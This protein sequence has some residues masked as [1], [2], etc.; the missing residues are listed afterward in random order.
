MDKI[1]LV[2]TAHYDFK[3]R[4]RLDRLLESFSP[5]SIVV[6][7]SS[8]HYY[9]GAF[10]LKDLDWL[11]AKS[12]E[13]INKDPWAPMLFAMY[14]G[15]FYQGDRS[16]INEETTLLFLKN[17]VFETR[18][19]MKFS[20]ENGKKFI[21]VDHDPNHLLGKELLKSLGENEEYSSHRFNGIRELLKMSPEQATVESQKAYS[22]DN[23][24]HKRFSTK[25]GEI[26]TKMDDS[27]G[28]P[29]TQARG[30]IIVIAGLTHFFGPYQNLY[31][32]LR[33]TIPRVRRLK[34]SEIDTL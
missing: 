13:E 24:T 26:A 11:T 6:E 31:E 14:F 3:G 21:S 33:I 7:T 2:G 17:A 1:T 16:G 32:R 22:E 28:E 4:E 23:E 8:Q 10:G 15:Q 18:S 20:L 9:E 25:A 27:F 12:L 30:D 5:D 19:A 29:I 34:L